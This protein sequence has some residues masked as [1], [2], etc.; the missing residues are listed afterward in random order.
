M[1]RQPV[2]ILKYLPPETD[3]AGLIRLFDSYRSRYIG[4]QLIDDC[5]RQAGACVSQEELVGCLEAAL[6]NGDEKTCRDLVARMCRDNVPFM[7][8]AHEIAYLRDALIKLAVEAD[9]S[10]LVT[11]AVTFFDDLQD[12]LA[13][14]FLDDFLKILRTRNHV[15]LQH[16]AALS[17]KNL[18]VYFER[19]LAW[20]EKLTEAVAT[21]DVTAM[22]EMDHQNCEFGQWLHN[23]GMALIRDRSH[24]KEIVRI[25]ADMHGVVPDIRNAMA[26]GADS[27]PILARLKKA[28]NHSLDLGSE[29]SMLNSMVIMSVYS[30]DPMTGLLTRRSLD[31]IMLNQ[32]E[33]SRA[34][35]TPC[36]LLMCDLDHFKQI[37]DEHGHV[38][39]D[40][41]ILHFSQ[42]MREVLRQSDLLFRYGGEEF[43]IILPSTDY[44]QG[45]ALAEKLRARL[46]DQPM[47]VEQAK[48]DVRASFGLLEVHGRK[49]AFIDNELVRE[50]IQACDQKLY[51]AKQ[52]GRNQVA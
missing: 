28:E 7:I 20:M 11:A 52:R 21:R 33:I 5:S 2:N 42:V 10:N 45:M 14:V 46:N 40:Q 1:S 26:G 27:L 35:E 31:R 19:H 29:I 15:R 48:V 17:E 24:Y 47:S 39:G 22:P 8:V 43:L 37:N 41:A 18:L 23:E 50:L 12:H 34:T 9:E 25:H 51:L 49:T 13:Q 3:R 44:D 38:V 32:L 6:V 16:I 4:S 36:C 30:K